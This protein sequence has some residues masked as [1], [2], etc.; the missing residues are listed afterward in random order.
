M[1]SRSICYSWNQNSSRTLFLHVNAFFSLSHYPPHLSSLL[2]FFS[3]CYPLLHSLLSPCAR[4]HL[5]IMLI[6]PPLCSSRSDTV[7][8]LAG[9]NRLKR[10][11]FFF[12]QTSILERRS[13]FGLR[14][15]FW[16]IYSTITVY[17]TRRQYACLEAGKSF[18]STFVL[19]LILLTLNAHTVILMNSILSVSDAYLAWL[20]WA[21]MQKI[22]A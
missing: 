11:A 12:S 19:K 17:M 9:S 1:L 10:Y 3:H 13:W 20:C 6:S 8:S 16:I 15:F 2:F 21:S 5:F 18:S 22:H 7:I 4:S 14:L